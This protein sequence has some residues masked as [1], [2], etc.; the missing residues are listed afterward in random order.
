MGELEEKHRIIEEMLETVSQ[1]NK[2]AG[3]SIWYNVEDLY[4]LETEVSL[5]KLR[6]IEQNLLKQLE[7]ISQFDY[8]KCQPRYN[9]ELKSDEKGEIIS[10][11]ITEDLPR[12]YP[13]EVPPRIRS[14]LIRTFP[15]IDE[16]ILPTPEE[17]KEE[18]Y[19]IE[20]KKLQSTIGLQEDMEEI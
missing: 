17:I 2:K 4:R 13:Y 19:E 15:E 3:I 14:N 18:L 8:G 10:Y 20:W 7:C 5:E 1:Y 6:K 12:Y 9:L 16:I 11:D